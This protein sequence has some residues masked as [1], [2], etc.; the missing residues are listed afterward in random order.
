VLFDAGSGSTGATWNRSRKDFIGLIDGSFRRCLYDRANL[1]D[2]D[3]VAGPRTSAT[4]AR[5]IHE[6]LHAAG[7]PPPYVLVGR[8]YGG[9]NVRLFAAAYPSETRALVLIETLTPQFL[10]GMLALLTP[11]QRA[12]EIASFGDIETPMDEIA[13]GPLVAAA[14]LPDV[15]VLVVA[16]TKWH[17]GNEPWPSAWPGRDLDAL[18]A[19]AQED[20]ASAIPRGRL[21]VFEGGDHSLHVSAPERLAGEIND[22][23][24]AA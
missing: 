6:L 3:R 16:G 13:S 20:L 15:P 21:I 8:S 1:G 24:A 23:L 19:R 10:T 2:S 11:E 7:L 18:W 5:D 9:F 17:S 14:K 22:F 4:A 12:G